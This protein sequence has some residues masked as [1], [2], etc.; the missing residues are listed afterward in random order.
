MRHSLLGH[1]AYNEPICDIADTRD[2]GIHEQ[3][4][5]DTFKRAV[6]S[7][8]GSGDVWAPYLRFL[9]SRLTANFVRIISRYVYEF[10]PEIHRANCA[11][12]YY[13]CRFRGGG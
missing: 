8:L 13:S 6:R 3:V 1:P 9:V 12:H 7:V 2:T 5:Q 10:A 11:Y 4:E